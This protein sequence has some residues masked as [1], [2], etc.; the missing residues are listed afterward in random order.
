[1]P[2]THKNRTPQ[3]LKFNFMPFLPGEEYVLNSLKTL[4][5]GAVHL[6]P[7][8]FIKGTEFDS[9]AQTSAN[10]RMLNT[11]IVLGIS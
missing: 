5:S 11:I 4:L 8:R 7:I 2:L 6:H 1:V 10:F 3:A 9:C